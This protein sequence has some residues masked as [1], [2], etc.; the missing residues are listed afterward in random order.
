MSNIQLN[1]NYILV[2][3]IKMNNTLY[4]LH[5][6]RVSQGSIVAKLVDFDSILSGG[7]ST[8]Q[9]EVRINIARFSNPIKSLTKHKIAKK[10]NL[11]I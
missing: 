6:C 11:E 2:L 7:F 9:Q 4:T 8:D 10:N 5:E 3:K 1:K